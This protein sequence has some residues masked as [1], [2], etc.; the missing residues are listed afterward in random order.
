[1]TRDW[2]DFARR[3]LRPGRPRLPEARAVVIGMTDVREAWEALVVR[4]LVPGPE[5]ADRGAFRERALPA[6]G[7]RWEPLRD[8][9]TASNDPPLP[10]SIDA[11]VTLACDPRGVAQA[12]VLALAF[13]AHSLPW[14]LPSAPRV[15]PT[16][17]A[18]KVVAAER[19]HQDYLR[20]YRMAMIVHELAA[21]LRV[22][23]PTLASVRSV[24]AVLDLTG[25][26]YSHRVAEDAAAYELWQQVTARDLRRPDGTR[27]RELPDPTTPLI[28]LWS[29]GYALDAVRGDTVVLVAPAL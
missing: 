14:E 29:T 21:L 24:R 25:E 9:R 13:A 7:P 3:V 28:D 23:A 12:G 27:Y 18:W 17:V 15:A 20:R 19:W 22:R 1:M 6:E 2:T 26:A 4:G 8:D 10:D 11:A 16:R 5:R